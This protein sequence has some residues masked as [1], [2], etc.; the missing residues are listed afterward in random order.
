MTTDAFLSAIFLGILE[1]LTEYLPVSSTGHL[2]VLSGLFGSNDEKGKVLAIVI[3]LGALLA[4]CW[5]QRRRFARALGGWRTD[6]QQRRF[7]ANLGIAFVPAFPGQRRLTSGGQ[8]LLA[9]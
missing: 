8:H 9:I 6:E 1:G 5:E 2:I 7:I 4:V 3:Q